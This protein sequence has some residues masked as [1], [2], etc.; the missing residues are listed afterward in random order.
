MLRDRIAT[1][2]PTDNDFVLL[3][4]RGALGRRMV[5]AARDVPARFVAYGSDPAADVPPNVEFRQA[6]YDSFATDLAACRAV[7]CAGGQQL[8]GEARYFGK[9]LLVV[10]IPRQH[11]QEINARYAALDG[12]GEYCP[13][14]D[15]SR[16]RIIAFLNRR[17]TIS[18]SANGVDQ[19]LDLLGIRNGR[20]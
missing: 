2:D 6:S 8:I 4:G 17:F 14:E 7:L 19:A 10:P 16:D 9:P 5:A 13:I 20:M 12:L 11:E 1:L 3:Y 15:L 18:R